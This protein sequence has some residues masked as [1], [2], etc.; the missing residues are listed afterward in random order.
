[1]SSPYTDRF[2]HPLTA[3]ETLRRMNS[4]KSRGYYD[5]HGR[6]VRL[7]VKR[8]AVERTPTETKSTTTTTGKGD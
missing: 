3:V 1:M 2:S 7:P 6:W 8:P 5:K 4:P